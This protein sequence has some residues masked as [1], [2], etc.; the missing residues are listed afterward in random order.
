MKNETRKHDKSAGDKGKSS[1]NKGEISGQNKNEVSRYV[2][3]E[4]SCC[5]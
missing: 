4:I 5:D 3:D 1:C 2:K